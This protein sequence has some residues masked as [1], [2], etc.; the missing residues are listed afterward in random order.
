M[1]CAACGGGGGGGGG[2]G[3]GSAVDGLNARLVAAVCQAR[4][5]CGLEPDAASCSTRLR[6]LVSD[7]V[8]SLV[9][10]GR[11][12]YDPD[13]GDACVA[14]LGAAACDSDD[15]ELRF[16][17]REDLPPPPAGFDNPCDQMFTGSLDG[18]VACE[19]GTECDTPLRATWLADTRCAFKAGCTPP[20]CSGE[21]VPQLECGGLC[22]HDAE[23]APGLYCDAVGA[24]ELPFESGDSCDEP[25][26]CEYPSQCE[27]ILGGQ[28]TCSNPGAPAA[29][30]A[31]C[32]PESGC[33]EISDACGSGSAA[34]CTPL[35]G[36]GS[37][38][39]S[40]APCVPDATCTSGTCQ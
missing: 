18:G 6:P 4:A 16:A 15:P 36:F 31:A 27:D 5:T 40:D 28:G 7:V 21:C 38:C 29:T 25:S 8:V 19:D 22:H 3:T 30:G 24:C 34:T 33:T 11:V 35:A 20:G 13:L 12:T 2:S 14:A 39:G 32:T 10:A 37:A 17:L 1:A 26:G 9:H 23:C